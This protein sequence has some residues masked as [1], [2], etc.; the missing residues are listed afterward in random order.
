MG[1]EL[2]DATSIGLLSGVAV[3]LPACNVILSNRVAHAGSTRNHAPLAHL[4]SDIG[5]A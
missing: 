5:L 2:V 1:Y 3:S 4:T